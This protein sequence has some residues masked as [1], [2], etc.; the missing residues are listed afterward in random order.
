MR[1][2]YCDSQKILASNMLYSLDRE[3]PRTT[4][5]HLQGVSKRR[6]AVSGREEGRALELRMC[7]S[8]NDQL[9]LVKLI[10]YLFLFF[11]FKSF[12]CKIST[13]QRFPIYLLLVIYKKSFVQAFRKPLY[14]LKA[15][16]LFKY[17]CY[18]PA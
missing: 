10:S 9:N 3:H 4:Y 13:C 18:H 7:K 16:G 14:I 1:N 8:T 11:F 6:S 17:I 12:N 5:A 2:L 15:A